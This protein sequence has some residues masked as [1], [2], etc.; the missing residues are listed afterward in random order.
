MGKCCKNG[1]CSSNEGG[2]QR[3]GISAVGQGIGGDTGLPVVLPGATKPTQRS[4]VPPI[5][6]LG[7]VVFL[8]GVVS[9]GLGFMLGDNGGVSHYLIV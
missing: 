3:F 8:S 1:Q 2:A 5:K 4:K 6:I 7:I 9:L